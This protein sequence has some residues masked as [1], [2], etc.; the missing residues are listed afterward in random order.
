MK[1]ILVLLSII[2]MGF[3]VVAV[4][5]SGDGSEPPSYKYTVTGQCP[6]ITIQVDSVFFSAKATSAKPGSPVPIGRVIDTTVTFFNKA[7]RTNIPGVGDIWRLCV[8]VE[9]TAVMIPYFSAFSL[10]AGCT[11]HTYSPD[12]KAMNGGYTGSDNPGGKATSLTPIAGNSMVMELFIPRGTAVSPDITLSGLAFIPDKASADFG[13]SGNCEVN[14]NCEEG[15]AW[16]T[17]KK[18]VVRILIRNGFS[19]YW[20]TGS[21]VN[22]TS[23]DKTPYILTANHCGKGATAENLNQWQF[24][25]NYESMGCP[26]PITEP[27]KQM[28]IGGKKVAAS[29]LSN[30]RLGS[31]FFLLRLNQGIP[32]DFLSY[33]S[34]WSTL[35]EPSPT[36]VSIHHPQGDIKKISTYT[37]PLVSTSWD[38]T[39]NTHWRVVWAKTANG[40]GVTEGGSSGSPVFNPEGLIVGTLT[41]GQASC[42]SANLTQPDYYGKFFYHWD[43]NGTADTL[44]LKPFLDPGN[45]GTTVLSGMPLSAGNRSG[46]ASMQLFPNPAVD[47]TQILTTANYSGPATV[48]ILDMHGRILQKNEMPELS[49]QPLHVGNLSAGMYLVIVKTRQGDVH[50]KMIKR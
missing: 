16:Q 6:I 44:Q 17:Q 33:F 4:A 1:K 30:N 18:S 36:G 29:D 5:Q 39:P 41:G 19:V 27:V 2:L 23:L 20:C 15:V 49:G 14:V 46:M 22:N 13:G 8:T 47:Y 48:S 3:V 38:N 45:T 37:T 50:L 32:T 42:D 28:L 34:G 24:V 11:F 12:G 35:N 21:L 9:G 10:P 7:E 26:S 43:Q 40:H 31:D 25:F